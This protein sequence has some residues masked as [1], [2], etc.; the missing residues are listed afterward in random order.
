MATHDDGDVNS[1]QT[2][3]TG[4]T[5]GGTTGAFRDV[6]AKD[7]ARRGKPP[8]HLVDMSPE[9]RVAAAKAIGMPKFRVKQLANHYFAH[10]D[11]DVES[12]TDFP[13]KLSATAQEA[14]FPELIH[15]VTH[16]SADEGTTIKTLWRLFDGAMIESVLMRYPS[17]TPCAS[18]AK[19]VVGWAAHSAPRASS[20]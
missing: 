1:G 7:H 6:L 5:P 12:F 13:S 10:F 18:Q 3:E 15:E 8:V 20:D 2:P 14:F 4:I 16:Q 11:T 17:R 9:E 19:S